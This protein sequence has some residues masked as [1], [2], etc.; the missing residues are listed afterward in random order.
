M[1]PLIVL[2]VITIA[3][4]FIYYKYNKIGKWLAGVYFS[5]WAVWFGTLSVIS[6]VTSQLIFES[7]YFVI[8]AILSGAIGYVFI[9]NKGIA[10]ESILKKVWKR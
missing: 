1:I 2:A 9:T 6:I 5:L 4:M 8:M 10:K 7:I 3:I